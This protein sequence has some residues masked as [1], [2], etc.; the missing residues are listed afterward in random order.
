[1]GT[2][3]APPGSAI[4]VPTL[5]VSPT[6]TTGLAGAPMCMDMGIV[7]VFGGSIRTADVLAVFFLWGTCTPL[8]EKAILSVTFLL[9]YTPRQC[10]LRM[11]IQIKVYNI[12]VSLSRVLPYFSPIIRTFQQILTFSNHFRHLTRQTSILKSPLLGQS[13]CKNGVADK[14]SFP[15]YKNS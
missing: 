6:L 15:L 9:F 11:Y 14:R 10:R 8:R 4:S 12:F 5:T 7:T 3:T 2:D 13:F 1:M